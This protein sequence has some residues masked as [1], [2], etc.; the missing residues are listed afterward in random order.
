MFISSHTNA[1][2]EAY[3][4]PLPLKLLLV[5]KYEPE[6]QS[7]DTASFSAS[8]TYTVSPAMAPIR[9]TPS[10]P[11]PVGA[12]TYRH[13]ITKESLK[14]AHDK[15]GK[16][17]GNTRQMMALH[18]HTMHMIA[19]RGFE[20]AGPLPT[21]ATQRPLLKRRY[22]VDVLTVRENPKR[23]R[24]MLSKEE[25]KVRLDSAKRKVF[26]NTD[27]QQTEDEQEQGVQEEM[28]KV[29][30]EDSM[31]FPN[32]SRYHEL[33]VGEAAMVPLNE[34]T[35]LSLNDQAVTNLA[36]YYMTKQRNWGRENWMRDDSLSMALMILG[37]DKDCE[38][39]NIAIAR[40]VETMAIYNVKKFGEDPQG[41]GMDWLRE[42]FGNA[43]WIFL[44]I[45]D[46]LRIRGRGFGGS[47][48]SLALMDMRA[49]RIHHYNAMGSN[50]RVAQAVSDILLDIL[51]EDEDEF[52]HFLDENSPSQSRHNRAEDDGGAACGPYVYKMTEYLIDQIRAAQEAGREETYSAN[53]PKGFGRQFKRIFHSHRV[54]ERMQASIIREKA[55]QLAEEIADAHDEAVFSQED[56]TLPDIPYGRN[57]DNPPSEANETSDDDDLETEEV[58]QQS[59]SDDDDDDNDSYFSDFSCSTAHEPDSDYEPDSDFDAKGETD[60]ESTP[61]PKATGRVP[62]SH[63]RAKSTPEPSLG[64]KLRSHT[65]AENATAPEEA[66]R[67]LRRSARNKQS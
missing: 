61:P 54:R 8:P 63:A 46:G 32:P 39:S 24:R 59:S 49:G 27:S 31:P 17:F 29:Q 50:L 23:K 4:Q 36:L 58:V 47:H 6:V 3:Q 53:L 65:R 57:Q 10:V 2:A 14:E 1:L 33:G 12:L 21:A 45:N 22:S 18:S 30:K 48:W 41:S 11:L 34:R 9:K 16:I 51:N 28:P 5:L 15:R 40:T 37:Q 19:S 13:G 64:R 66:G 52:E 60:D 38:A 7:H 56:I 43:R 55:K 26:M 20:R 67:V 35:Y 62:R 44:P 42:R 25:D